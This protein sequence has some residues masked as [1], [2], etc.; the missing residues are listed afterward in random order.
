M[1]KRWE[2]YQ[3]AVGADVVRKEMG[4]CRLTR[5]ETIKL[6]KLM[7]RAQEGA[8]LAKDRKDL[9]DG[10]L[11][12]RLD[13]GERIFRLFYGEVQGSNIA[14]LLAVKF[15]NKKSTQGI[16][17]DPTDIE[18][19]RKR[20]CEWQNRAKRDDQRPDTLK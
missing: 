15:V 19:A 20:L 17:T 12:L 4:K 1:T 3:T 16:A 5:A 14:L 13:C 18:T 9:R 2:F 10:L 8:L 6:G 7:Q 11:E